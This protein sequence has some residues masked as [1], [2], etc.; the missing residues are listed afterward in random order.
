LAGLSINWGPWAEVGMAAKL[1][2]AGQGIDK[3]DV[4]SGLQVFAELLQSTRGSS[5]ANAGVFRVNWPA[6][7]QRLPSDSAAAFISLLVQQEPKTKQGASADFLRR[8]HAT[9]EDD[10]AALLES[11][12]H[13]QLLQAL[14]QDAS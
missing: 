7:R 10:R 3:I 11:Y 5:L 4:D 6:F 13:G 8:F 12:I 1:S 2:L 9:V 14:G